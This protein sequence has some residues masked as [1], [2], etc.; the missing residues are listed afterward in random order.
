[1]YHEELHIFL[2]SFEDFHKISTSKYKVEF[3][4][5]D[6]SHGQFFYGEDGRPSI[7]VMESFDWSVTDQVTMTHELL[8]FTF[9]VLKTAGLK[10]SDESEEAYTYTLGYIQTKVWDKLKPKKKK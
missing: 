5:K 10:L 3:E 4:E 7:I 9:H 2:G 8:H 1:M 6:G